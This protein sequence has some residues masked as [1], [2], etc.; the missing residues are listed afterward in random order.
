MAGVPRTSRRVA[1]A[2]V[3]GL[4]LVLVLAAAALAHAASL[5]AGQRL[6]V[7]VTL[8]PR[9]PAALT[10]YARAVSTPGS[11]A[12][13][14]YL[15][16]AGFARRF[17]P[18][19]A[20][21][22]A[23]RGALRARG[24][25]PG[26]TSAGGLSIP[27]T[28][29]AGQLERGLSVGLSLR[30]LP[31]RRTAIAATAKPTLGPGAAGI[32]QAVLGLDTGSAP[33]PLLQRAPLHAAAVPAAARVPHVATGGP[34]PCASAQTVAS[35]DNAHTADQIASAYGFPGLYGAGDQGAGVTIAVYE[36][37]PNSAADI[38]AYQS[39]YGTH[40]S[41]SYVP[42]DGGSGTGSGSGEAALDIENLIG[43][44][45]AANVLVYQGPNSNS[46]G[47]GSGP[48]DTFAA[49]VNQDRAR[50]VSVSWGQCE[51]ALGAGNAAAENTLFAQ[52]AVQGQTIVAASGD[53]GSEDCDTGG[54]LPQTELAVDDPSSQPFVTGVGGTTL[55]S[56]GPRPT[57]SVWNGGG[58]LAMGLLQPGAGGG[59]ISSLWPMPA[60]QLGAPASAGVVGPGS[61]G[62]P[63]GRSGGYCRQVPDV[64]AD[65]D[66]STGYV[67]YWNGDGSA[68]Q[69]SGWQSIGGTSAAAPV[70]A[71]LL[72]LTDASPRCAGGP[73]GFAG[74]ALYRAAGSTYA[75]DFNDISTGNNDFT[76]TNG[77]S[78]AARRG[79]DEA[80][81]LGSPNASALAADL[82][83]DSLHLPTPRAQRL[84]ARSVVSLRLRATDA[85]GAAVTYGAHGLP[86][87][88]SLNQATG[89]ITGS[90][91]RP[92]IFGV[93]VAAQ[94]PQG[95]TA[96]ATFRITVGAASKLSRVSLAGVAQRRPVLSFRVGAG[97]SAPA[98]S[99]VSVSLPSYLQ[100]GS[101]RGVRVTARDVRRV[102]FA[103]RLSHGALALT[104]RRTL[105]EL[106][107]SL[108]APEL[109]VLS[110]RL[111]RSRGHGRATS[112]LSLK[113]TDAAGGETRLSDRLAASGRSS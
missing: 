46:A 105:T 75:G 10:A 57:E 81:G 44:A 56:L 108:S 78:Y 96:S 55:Q 89:R 38:A 9:D 20:Q 4:V 69:P 76:G 37:E 113:L 5:P 18:T 52:A 109:R 94:D 111:P 21:I 50:V 68:G 8:R 29:T 51:P 26:A 28:A 106:T 63:C 39:C 82:C 22:S 98:L 6:H 88:L 102:R 71:A 11:S 79:Y 14:H 27:V 33:R 74:P 36:L 62:S 12:Y 41:V 2:V 54:V 15:T 24:L 25:H 87:G 72:A 3:L 67:I 86:P 103:A 31:G 91:R 45:P 100:L 19:P 66:P 32:V 48:Y 110:Q 60:D 42:V 95:S 84:A 1:L 93:G 99:R 7:T 17:G 92:G 90:P 61:S 77:G 65:A 107:V 43:M 23:V 47:P 53:S 70:W 104:L 101:T 13:L 83:A 80:S 64:S 58:N 16:P 73:L 112:K 97:R 49:I 85:R 34:Q 40:T 35:S 59:G 30:S